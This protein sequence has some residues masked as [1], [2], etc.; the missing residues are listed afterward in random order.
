LLGKRL[1]DG[2]DAP[3]CAMLVQRQVQRHDGLFDMV[4]CVGRVAL[5]SFGPFLGPDGIVCIVAIPPLVEPTFRAGQL[6]T[7]VL[8]LVCGKICVDGLFT[9]LFWVLGHRGC[10]RELRLH[11][12]EHPLFAMLWHTSWY[13]PGSLQA[14]RRDSGA[15][16]NA[17]RCQHRCTQER[18]TVSHQPYGSGITT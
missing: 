9:A 1:Y 18:E 6:P 15:T 5:G 13:V 7:D 16:R 10:L 12:R 2:D 11:V 3:I 14:L 8:D 4:R 17:W